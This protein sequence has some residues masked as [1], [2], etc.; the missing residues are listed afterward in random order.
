[1]TTAPRRLFAG[2]AAFVFVAVFFAVPLYAVATMCIHPCCHATRAAGQATVK[3]DAPPC[4]PQCSIRTIDAMAAK[5]VRTIVPPARAAVDAA[6][7]AAVVAI[8]APAETLSANA[9]C[10]GPPCNS[11]TPVHLLNSVFRI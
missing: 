11:A 7:A 3:T 4:M 2:A 1:M 6:P 10:E 8:V 9:S 5:S